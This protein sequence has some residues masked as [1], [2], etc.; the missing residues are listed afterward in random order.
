MED[1][2]QFKIAEVN[3]KDQWEEL[4]ESCAEKTFMQSWS[5]REWRQAMGQKVGLLGVW[6]KDKLIAGALYVIMPMIKKFGLDF[7]F[8]FIPHGP[9]IRDEHESQKNKIIFEIANY[10]KALAQEN[11]NIIFIRI[12]PA[13]IK[14][15]LEAKLFKKSGWQ[16]APMFITPEVTWTLDISQPEEKILREMRKT[17]RYLIKKGLGNSDLI[18]T[19][20]TDSKDLNNFLKL[21]KETVGR[22]HFQAFTLDYLKKELD[23]LKKENQILI[24]NALYQGKPIASGMIVFYQKTAYYHQGASSAFQPKDAPGSYL[25]QWAAIQ[26]ARKR[27][28]QFYNFWGIADKDNPHH[29][30]YGLSLFKKGFGGFRTDYFQTHDIPLRWWYWLNYF[31]EKNRRRRRKL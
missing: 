2:N 28:C 6:H 25:I 26:E 15:I 13:W 30:Y 16:K 20:G 4:N 3:D 8:I 27:G 21:Y 10:L 23:C 29:A 7:S 11:K 31:L 9:I 22:H 17:T 14:N 1:T 19:S 24:L 12:A 5:S 18:I